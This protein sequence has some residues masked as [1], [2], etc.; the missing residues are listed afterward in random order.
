[1]APIFRHGKDTRVL[2][3]QY[4][5]GGILNDASHDASVDT[6]ETTVFGL[7]DKTYLAGLADNTVS[8]K[9]LYDGAFSTVAFSANRVHELLQTALGSSTGVINTYGPEGD[10][11][12][13]RAVLFLG[14]PTSLKISSPIGDAVKVESEQFMTA[15]LARG[16]WLVSPSAAATVSTYATVDHGVLTS[17]GG[18]VHA[19]VPSFT[20][21]GTWTWKVQH[22][23][24]GS[25]FTD[26]TTAR[27]LNGATRFQ[28]VEV[29]GTVKRYAKAVVSAVTGGSAPL[30]GIAY[31][32]I[33]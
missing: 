5:L 7:S 16:Y 12:G 19:H 1:M 15:P 33:L 31:G 9:G 13:R 17:H 3:N 10:T 30:I 24:N 21:T 28:R 27:S 29:T 11:L 4:N 14:D 2:A 25:A 20:A 32:R 26:L 8:Y 18:A 22:S 23:S 6:A